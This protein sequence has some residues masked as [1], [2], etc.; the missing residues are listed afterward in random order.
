MSQRE[1]YNNNYFDSNLPTD[2]EL[3]KMIRDERDYEIDYYNNYYFGYANLPTQK[4]LRKLYYRTNRNYILMYL[5]IW[6]K[7][8][9]YY[10][11]MWLSLHPNYMKN[12]YQNN[13]HRIL[14]YKRQT[15]LRKKIFNTFKKRE[16]KT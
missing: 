15:Y 14:E 3:R 10:M 9:P 5:G 11:K 2:K 4:E 1:D 8:N 7:H 13:R 12:Y 16:N 6:R